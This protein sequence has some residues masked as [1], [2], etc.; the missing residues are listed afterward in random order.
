VYAFPLVPWLCLDLV[1]SA[2]GDEI[3]ARHL[4]GD[5]EAISRLLGSVALGGIALGVAAIAGDVILNR[6]AFASDH[7]SLM[8]MVDV[9][10][11]VAGKMP[12]SPAYFSAAPAGLTALRMAPIGPAQI[13]PRL[14]IR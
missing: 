8:G 13:L 11:S 2:I 12:P 14:I 3:G 7:Q 4:R 1:G 6:S 5:G 9:L 10:T